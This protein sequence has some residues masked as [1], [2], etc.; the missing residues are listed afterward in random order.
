MKHQS[1]IYQFFSDSFIPW[2]L[3]YGSTSIC[4]WVIGYLATTSIFVLFVK[5][6]INED[7]NEKEKI[8]SKH[9]I[10]LKYASIWENILLFVIIITLL[11]IIWP[12][13]LGMYFFTKTLKKE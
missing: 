8:A 5:E 6:L 1:S 12:I 11:L 4:I 13:M 10:P 7:V 3:T 9:K 2:A